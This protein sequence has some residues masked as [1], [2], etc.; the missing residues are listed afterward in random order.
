VA[1]AIIVVVGGG[2]GAVGVGP[3]PVVPLVV[4]ASSVAGAF[5]GIADVA[6]GVVVVVVSAVL[7]GGAEGP[8]RASAVAVGGDAIAV[9]VGRA[10]IRDTGV[11]RTGRLDPPR[12]V[13]P[14]VTATTRSGMRIAGM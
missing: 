8:P 10:P 13:R 4:V 9:V 7:G 3:T 5:A 12:V 1:V 11:V 14:M 6:P 2:P